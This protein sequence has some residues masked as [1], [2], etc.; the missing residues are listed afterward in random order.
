[1]QNFYIIRTACPG[2]VS[3]HFQVFPWQN[4]DSLKKQSHCIITKLGSQA[5]D[6]SPLNVENLEDA[7]QISNQVI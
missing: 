4:P 7:N 5:G 6:N 1:M 3:C 2:A